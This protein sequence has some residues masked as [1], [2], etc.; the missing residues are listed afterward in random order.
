[1][2]VKKLLYEAEDPDMALLI[3]RSTRF[4][5]CNLSPAELLMG[6]QLRANI[7]LDEDKLSP[8]WNYLE[9]FR[10]LQNKKFK[11]RRRRDFDQ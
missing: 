9:Q 4:P 3:Y 2:T 6:R 5:W 1:M 10:L 11:E 7:P 8:E